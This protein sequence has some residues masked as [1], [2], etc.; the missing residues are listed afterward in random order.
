MKLG[1]F[2]YLERHQVSV[3]PPAYRLFD[4]ILAALAL[5]VDGDGDAAG[6]SAHVRLLLGTVSQPAVVQAVTEPFLLHAVPGIERARMGWQRLQASGKANWTFGHLL[7]LHLE[8][9]TSGLSLEFPFVDGSIA[10][11]RVKLGDLSVSGELP[12]TF[13]LAE[14]FGDAVKLED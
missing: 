13:S 10:T 11:F 5:E 14:Y 6:A 4:H 12:E 3:L 7:F 2:D 1:Y 8:H 9:N